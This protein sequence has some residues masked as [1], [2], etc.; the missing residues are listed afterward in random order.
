MKRRTKPLAWRLHQSSL[1]PNPFVA[2]LGQT[3]RSS[4]TSWLNI[5]SQEWWQKTP[6]T[7]HK[8]P[9]QTFHTADLLN[10]DRKNGNNG[11][12]PASHRSLQAE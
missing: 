1:V 7:C 2:Y 3:I 4:I 5:Q 10:Q 6:K 9:L 11:C 12:R 8:R